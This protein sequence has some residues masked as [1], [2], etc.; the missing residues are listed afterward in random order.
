MITTIS[1]A[2]RRRRRWPY[3]RRRRCC[4]SRRRDNGGVGTPGVVVSTAKLASAPHHYAPTR[5][6]DERNRNVSS[7]S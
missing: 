6:S 3:R 1:L 4:W 7:Y 2:V 5:R